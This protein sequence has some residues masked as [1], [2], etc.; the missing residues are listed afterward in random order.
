MNDTDPLGI[1]LVSSG[2]RGDRL[3]FRF[4]Y[5]T[6]ES[7]ETTYEGTKSCGCCII[8][9]QKFT[10]CKQIMIETRA[11]LNSPAHIFGHRLPIPNGTPYLTVSGTMAAPIIADPLQLG[12]GTYLN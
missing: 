3:C 1:F 5:D 4:P 11:A 2:S 10:N 9:Q 6:E 8:A 7:K 12:L